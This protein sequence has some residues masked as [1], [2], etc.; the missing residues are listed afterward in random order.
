[1]AR[2]TLRVHGKTLMDS[3]FRVREVYLRPHRRPVAAQTVSR[4]HVRHVAQVAVLTRLWRFAEPQRGMAQPA[5]ARAVR[6]TQPDVARVR[7]GLD[8]RPCGRRVAGRAT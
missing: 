3:Q 7:D 6:R 5:R 1:M 2:Q 4:T 8:G